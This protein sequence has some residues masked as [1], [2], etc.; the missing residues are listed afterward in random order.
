MTGSIDSP[1]S[2]QRQPSTSSEL[3]DSFIRLTI[4]RPWQR[5]HCIE[6]SSASYLQHLPQCICPDNARIDGFSLISMAKP[7]PGPPDEHQESD[8]ARPPSANIPVPPQCPFSERCQP[9]PSTSTARIDRA[10]YKSSTT[11]GLRPTLA[12]FGNDSNL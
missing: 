3:D 1:H 10:L 4:M 8:H 9:Q 2:R 12:F 5:R 7:K 6:F 11:T